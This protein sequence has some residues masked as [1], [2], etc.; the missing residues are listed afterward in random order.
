MASTKVP[1]PAGEAASTFERGDI[2]L[3]ELMDDT[4]SLLAVHGGVG[5]AKEINRIVPLWVPPPGGEAPLSLYRGTVQRQRGGASVGR[6]GR[7]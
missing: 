4:L 2:T 5:A 3:G 7:Q 6:V 1:R